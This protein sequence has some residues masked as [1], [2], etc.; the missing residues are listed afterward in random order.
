[1]IIPE[2]N[3]RE[4]SKYLFQE[5]VC[6][7]KKD[8]N[9]AK[10][11]KIDV[12]NLQ[13][14]WWKAWLWPW[15]WRKLVVMDPNLKLASNRGSTSPKQ[16]HIANSSDMISSLPDAVLGC[17]LSLVPK[18]DAMR[19]SVLSKRWKRLWLSVSHYVFDEHSQGDRILFVNLLNRVIHRETYIDKLSNVVTYMIHCFFIH[20]CA[21]LESLILVF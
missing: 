15:I 7:A 5:G 4:I 6:Y 3:R 11:P 9:L 21:M 1:M 2:K 13:G 19:T 8:F 17:I 10:H 12:P 20:S 18:K 14:F 16:L